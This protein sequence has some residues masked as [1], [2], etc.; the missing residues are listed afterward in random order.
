MTLENPIH[1]PILFLFLYG[2]PFAYAFPLSFPF[3]FLT[4][5]PALSP[6]MPPVTT[7]AVLGDVDVASDI[8]DQGLA[9]DVVVLGPDE[10]HD[11][12]V[13]LRAVEVAR[14]ELKEVDFLDGWCFFDL[15]FQIGR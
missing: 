9:R 8:L 12:Q 4:C 13:Q 5:G 6:P 3:L 1:I 11:Q 7:Q 2:H 15:A 14:E 10:A